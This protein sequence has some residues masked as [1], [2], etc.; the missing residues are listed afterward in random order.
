[1]AV[2][3][4]DTLEAITDDWAGA[5]YKLI[6]L[7]GLNDYGVGDNDFGAFD[8]SDDAVIVI[9]ALID[10]DPINAVLR[11]SLATRDTM[12]G[13][14]IYGNAVKPCWVALD[15][16]AAKFGDTDFQTLNA[17]L[18][19]LNT[20]LGTKWQAQLDR[21][22]YDLYN[23]IKGGSNFPNVENIYFEVL[24][25]TFA[26][27]DHLFTSGLGHY[28]QSTTTFTQPT[29]EGELI[30]GGTSDAQI[31]NT[32]YSGGLGKMKVAS[33]AGAADD[34]TVTGRF[35]DPAT[36]LITANVTSI[37]NV[38]GDGT[39]TMVPGA[40]TMPTDSLLIEVVSVI[41]GGNIT[42]ASIFFEAHRPAGRPLLK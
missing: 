18:S 27:E 36:K 38:T 7:D 12:I 26:D 39:I 23:V 1:M 34:V 13:N 21:K 19:Y 37:T 10:P 4:A 35:F 3:T 14:T 31:D 2:I 22:W 24:E 28:L 29:L 9:A 20:A 8:L 33:F 40:G 6:G 41:V 17:Y 32:K 11:Q 15:K 30:A 25:G 5:A 16:H 42:E